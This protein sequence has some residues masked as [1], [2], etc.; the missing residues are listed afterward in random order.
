VATFGG[1]EEN[2]AKFFI[3]N[4]STF[5]LSKDNVRFFQNKAFEEQARHVFDPTKFD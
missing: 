2:W 3:Y 1:I 5:A 4:P